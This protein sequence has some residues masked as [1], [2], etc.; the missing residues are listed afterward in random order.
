MY[1]L[2][3]HY[4]DFIPDVVTILFYYKYQYSG[5]KFL[6]SMNF[7]EIGDQIFNLPMLWNEAYQL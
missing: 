2:T 3:L 7:S 1:E 5:K 4:D 6:F